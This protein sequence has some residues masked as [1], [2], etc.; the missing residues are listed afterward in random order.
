MATRPPGK[1][2][3]PNA[4]R[5][6]RPESP[7]G[8]AQGPPRAESAVLKRN[9]RLADYWDEHLRFYQ[10]VKDA[11]RPKT[12]LAEHN[13]RTRWLKHLGDPRLNEITQAH[14]NG[15]I[16][17]RQAAGMSPGTVNLGVIALRNV[18]KRAVGRFTEGPADGKPATAQS[19]SEETSTHFR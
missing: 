15:F 9:P 17:R 7:A 19:G 4:A 3:W 14:L 2:V 5:W 8:F 6:P 12:L 11:K 16:S 18:L 10:Q 1:S 13:A